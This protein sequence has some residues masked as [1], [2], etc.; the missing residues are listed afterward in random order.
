MTELN[1][2]ELAIL[3]GL[4]AGLTNIE[5]GNA[6]HISEDT[7]KTRVRRILAKLNARNRTHIVG[8]AYRNGLLRTDTTVAAANTAASAAGAAERE[9]L[10]RA[11]DGLAKQLRTS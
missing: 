1:Q 7:V 3:P 2:G 4:A 5:I 10:A 9:R 11:L 6:H 8:I